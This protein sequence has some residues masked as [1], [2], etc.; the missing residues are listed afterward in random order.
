MQDF[1]G[2]IGATRCGL[3]LQVCA[4]FIATFHNTRNTALCSACRFECALGVLK[5]RDRCCAIHAI[6][7]LTMAG[8]VQADALV[9][10][11]NSHPHEA[12]EHEKNRCGYECCVDRSGRGSEDFNPKQPQTAAV[13]ESAIL[14]KDTREACANEAGHTVA[15]E[16]IQVVVHPAMAQLE[17]WVDQ[18][19]PPEAHH[20]RSKRRHVACCGCD[21]DQPYDGSGHHACRRR[22]LVL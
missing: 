15:R 10:F 9:V 1:L 17:G 5:W 11:M 2:A 13:Q 8:I 22:A 19:A 21:D 4:I 7:H 6:S 3:C 20:E 16:G 14:G 18:G 12:A